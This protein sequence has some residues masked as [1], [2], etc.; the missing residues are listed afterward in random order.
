M[1]GI[2]L[3]DPADRDLE[4]AIEISQKLLLKINICKPWLIICCVNLRIDRMKFLWN[5]T[6]ENK[7][8]LHFMI[9]SWSSG[10]SL[11][12]ILRFLENLP[13]IINCWNVSTPYNHLAIAIAY[14]F[15]YFLQY[16]SSST[17]L[18]S[19]PSLRLTVT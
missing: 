7:W 2:I 3:F 18:H 12:E 15:A 17:K 11:R 6:N 9:C 5:S 13:F 1:I 10:I 19:T 14:E 8:K 16:P 4:A